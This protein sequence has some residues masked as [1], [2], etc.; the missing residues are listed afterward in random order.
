MSPPPSIS[1]FNVLVAETDNHAMT[2][3][4]TI[5]SEKNKENKTVK[6]KA[7]LDTGAGGKFIDQNYVNHLNLET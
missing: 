2:I 4:I 5:S 7:L 6:T 3:S 1:I